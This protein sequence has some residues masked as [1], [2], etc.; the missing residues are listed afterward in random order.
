MTRR[1]FPTTRTGRTLTSAVLLGVLLTGCT[2]STTSVSLSEAETTT[3]QTDEGSAEVVQIVD[4]DVFDSS[5]LHDVDLT[6]DEAD[7]V[8]LLE[9]YQSSGRGAGLQHRANMGLCSQIRCFG[10]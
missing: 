5:V 7:L 6:I 3:A 8:E 1:P 9:T 4:T 10:G 2:A